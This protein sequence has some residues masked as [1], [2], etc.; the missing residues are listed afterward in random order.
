MATVAGATLLTAAGVFA[1]PTASASPQEPASVA[2]AAPTHGST[3]FPPT[4]NSAWAYDPSGSPG[5][6]VDAVRNYE[7][8]ATP[9]REMNEIYSFGT[10]LVMSCPD[11]DGT[12]CTASDLRS[13]YTPGS[14]GYA[15]TDAYY[16]AF[17][18]PH[19]GSLAIAPILDGYTG[20]VGGYTR[21]FSQLSPDLAAGYADKVASQFCA[22]PR[23]SGVQAD[24]EPFDVTTKNGQYYFYMQLAKDFAGKHTDN[25]VQDPYGCVDATHP[26]G[27]FFSVFNFSTAI[28]PGTQSAANVQ[29][30]TNTYGNGYF[31]DS[32]YDLSSAPAFTLNGIGT[33]K[34]AV[35]REAADT[36]RWA[37]ELHIKY[38]FGIPAASTSHEYTTCT[39]M[40][41]ATASCVPDATGATGYPMIDYAK[42]A[43]NAINRTG[44]TGDPDYLGTAI[45]G[46]FVAGPG[47][48]GVVVGPTP[49][50]ADVLSY[51]A[52]NLPAARRN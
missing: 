24:V 9:G 20:K 26:H 6:W 43:V 34:P 44:A 40:P 33:Y 28:K 23:V 47:D 35:R 18:V 16:R 19:P 11:N 39:A 4:A 1:A 12:Q 46:F 29:D 41:N 48:V 27:R 15:A 21:G 3:A 36:K 17:D 37:N 31:M 42:A 49:A 7:Q 5:K 8:Q 32:L 51:F 50:P 25:T 13:D 2:S 38:G 45:W 14:G 30:I 52:T 10:S 22:D